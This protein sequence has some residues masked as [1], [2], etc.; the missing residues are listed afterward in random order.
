MEVTIKMQGSL[1]GRIIPLATVAVLAAAPLLAVEVYVPAINPGLNNDGSR[2]ETELWVGNAG[3]KAGSFTTTYFDVNSDGTH[4]AGV[5][6]ST[7][8]VPAGRSFQVTGV[9]KSGQAG[10]VV[11]GLDSGMVADARLV[12]TAQSGAIAISSVPVISTA[13]QVDAGGKAELLGLERDPENGRLLHFGVVN[14]G[15]AAASCMVS[16]FRVDGSQIASTVTLALKPL[17]LLHFQD[18]LGILDAGRV[19]GVRGEVSC[20]QPFFAYGA[21]QQFPNAHYQFVTPTTE[22]GDAPSQ[23]ITCQAG[24][25][26]YDFPG[27]VHTSTSANPDHAVRLNPPPGTYKKVAVHLE[28]QIN[29]FSAPSDGGHGMLYMV[30]DKNKDMFGYIFLQGPNANR[31]VLRHGFGQTTGAKAK[32]I[33]AFTPVN[34]A[35]YALDYVYDAAGRS[36]VMTLKKGGQ[37]VVRFADAPNIHSIG[38]GASQQIIL[39]LSNPGKVSNEPAS[40]GWVY[41]NLHVELTP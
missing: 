10:L 2:S 13:N 26:C 9:A 19:S 29:G 23:P 36:L 5:P 33:Q 6:S 27:I 3:T 17:S 40:I 15:G 38:I 37:E 20:D 18:A 35:T 28:V 25:V 4:R 7:H 39:G 31:V 11:I 12:S 41:K 22:G 14:L 34:G 21:Q 24:L 1:V 32:L 16:F 30:L 8:S